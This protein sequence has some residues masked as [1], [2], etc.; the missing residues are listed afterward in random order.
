MDFVIVSS[1]TPLMINSQTSDRVFVF[2]YNYFVSL[3]KFKICQNL[4]FSS[5]VDSSSFSRIC[6]TS[7]PYKVPIGTRTTILPSRLVNVH[8]SLT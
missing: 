6:L 5:P 4:V 3:Y 1:M 2:D 8:L 7:L